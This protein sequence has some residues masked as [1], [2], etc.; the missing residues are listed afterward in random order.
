MTS[1]REFLLNSKK[2]SVSVFIFMTILLMYLL[3]SSISSSQAESDHKKIVNIKIGHNLSESNQLRR[4]VLEPIAAE[5]YK[6]TNKKISFELNYCGVSNDCSISNLRSKLGSRRID[7]YFYSSSELSSPVE[8]N[9]QLIMQLPVNSG[10]SGKD[11]S[12]L[13]DVIWSELVSVSGSSRPSEVQAQFGGGADASIVG[14]MAYAKKELY[15]VPD[16]QNG[17]VESVI[18][19]RALAKYNVAELNSELI[20]YGMGNE[21]PMKYFLASPEDMAKLAVDVGILD[22]RSVSLNFGGF[23]HLNFGS[24]MAAL[25]IS[26]DVLNNELDDDTREKLF[27]ATEKITKEY[28]SFLSWQHRQTLLAHGI[29]RRTLNNKDLIEASKRLRIKA[30]VK[31]AKGDDVVELIA[32]ENIIAHHQISQRTGFTQKAI[33]SFVYALGRQ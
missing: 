9:P 17:K 21:K 29:S 7:G 23:R 1:L 4:A 2:I 6:L 5:V 11:L 16:L 10:A 3:I 19:R 26:N 15:Q 14:V 20:N 28:A 31:L 32:G 22:F 27:R 33:D 25:L 30:P 18:L 8:P 12:S 13:N 24:Q